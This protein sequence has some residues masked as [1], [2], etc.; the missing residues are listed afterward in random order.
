MLQSV[1]TFRYRRTSTPARLQ[2]LAEHA[3][4]STF[5]LYEPEEFTEALRIFMKRLP[6]PEV[7]WT[8]ENIMLVCECR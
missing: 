5:R 4:Y 2:Q 8:D 3:H 7:S 6:D 1:E